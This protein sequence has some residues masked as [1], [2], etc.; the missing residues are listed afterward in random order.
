MKFSIFI[1]DMLTILTFVFEHKFE[2]DVTENLND[3]DTKIISLCLWISFCSDKILLNVKWEIMI[4]FESIHDSWIHIMFIIFSKSYFRHDIIVFIDIT[5]LC[6]KN[7]IS[8]I[9]VSL[10]WLENY[11]FLF[12]FQS[13][14]NTRSLSCLQH[15]SRHNLRISMICENKIRFICV[16]NT[17]AFLCRDSL[18]KIYIWQMSLCMCW[19]NVRISDIYDIDWLD[20]SRIRWL[21]RLFRLQSNSF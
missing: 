7:F 6:C 2:R 18:H 14:E 3:F 13:L 4:W 12:W 20:C 21:V 16:L 1:F 8:W 17:Y 5:Q 10:M 11:H 9:I 15:V 19:L